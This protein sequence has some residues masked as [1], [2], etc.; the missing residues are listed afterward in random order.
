MVDCDVRDVNMG[1]IAL[2]ALVF[3]TKAPVIYSL[4]Y[5]LYTVTAVHRSTNPSTLRGTV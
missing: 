1:I 5:R 3:I 4:G 2:Q